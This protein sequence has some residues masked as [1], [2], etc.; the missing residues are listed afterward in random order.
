ME[1]KRF[2]MVCYAFPPVG[3]AGVQ[4][5]VK[6]VKYIGRHGWKPTVLSVLNPSVPALDVDLVRD[7][8]PEIEVLRARTLE[9]SYRIKENLIRSPTQQPSRIKLWLRGFAMR[10]L[11]PDAQILWNPFAFRAA[12]TSIQ[13][14]RYSAIYVSG[15]PFS[16]FLLGCQLKRRFQ[17]PLVLDFRDEW[18]LSSQYLEN[19]S[20]QAGAVRMQTRH[21]EYAIRQADAI[22]AT[23]EASAQELAKCCEKIGSPARARCIYNG[24]DPDDLLPLVRRADSTASFRLVY[25]GTLW[26]LTDVAP[27]VA[28][29]QKLSER[30]PLEAEKLELHFVGRRTSEQEAV[31]AKL[32]ETPVKLTLHNY[33]SHQQAL[34]FACDADALLLTLADEPGAERVVPGKLFEYLA[35]RNPILGILPDGESARLL[36]EHSTSKRVHPLDTDAI[37]DWLRQAIRGKSQPID[38]AKSVHDLTSLGWP[39]LDWCSRSAQAGQLARM[40]DELTKDGPS[41][42]NNQNP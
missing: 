12:L 32:S 18:N 37:A 28:A 40:L 39:S 20:Q 15:P 6:F 7:I 33:L 10:W 11:Q 41:D 25:T 8:P 36:L 17:I 42:R 27:L 1:V 22:I 21:F 9:P 38:H 13:R 35:L 2:L 29:V 23:T 31:L 4:R 24:Y 19:R 34:Q 3:G 5:S 14:H 26:R 16:S 30:F